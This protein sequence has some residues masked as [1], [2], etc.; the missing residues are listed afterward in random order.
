MPIQARPYIDNDLT[1]L[2]AALAGWINVAGDCGYYHVGNLPHWIYALLRGRRPVGE[3]VQVWGE[4]VRIVGI[5]VTCLFDN[6]FQVFASPLRRG[7]DAEF[8]MLQSAFETTRR[9][10]QASRRDDATVTTDVFSCDTARM[11][12]LARLGFAQYRLWD[13]INERSLSKAI[14]AAHAP[15]GFRIRSA[16]LDDAA[17]LALVRNDAFV[18]DW[19]AELYRTEVMQKPG[20]HP[21][22]EIVVVAPDGQIVAFTVIHFD[23]VNKVGLFEP[24]GVRRAFQRRGLARAMML[25]AMYE[26]QRQGM[27]MAMVNHDATNQAARELY[28]NL[29]FRKKYETLGYHIG[30]Q[31]NCA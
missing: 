4:G 23:P 20:Y 30:C 18:T 2:Q 11:E 13:H 27:T 6:A 28:R 7:T 3:L 21:K 12:L 25:Y 14:P 19:S 8:L 29:G 15:D 31:R 26:M 16:T 24:V 5:A 17:Q 9:F 22:N 1:R 10:V